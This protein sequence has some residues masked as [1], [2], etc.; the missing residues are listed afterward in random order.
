MPPPRRHGL[1]PDARLPACGEPERRRHE[2]ERRY[3]VRPPR[4]GEGSEIAAEADARKQIIVGLKRLAALLE[5]HP[6][7]PC[8]YSVTITEYV[9]MAQARVMSSP[10]LRHIFSSTSFE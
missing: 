7:L 10:F 8:P 1:L 3:A 6:D 9:D 4:G 2:D 5:V